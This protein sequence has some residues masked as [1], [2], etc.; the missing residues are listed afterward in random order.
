M[1]SRALK[2]IAVAAHQPVLFH[3]F[4]G[5]DR[6]GL[7]SALVLALLHTPRDDIANDY[8][9]SEVHGSSALGRA[10]F[11]KIP[12]LVRVHSAAACLV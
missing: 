5:K 7:V 11:E 1:L 9:L 10:Q 8:H 4:H 6:T 12:Q 3:C 2:I